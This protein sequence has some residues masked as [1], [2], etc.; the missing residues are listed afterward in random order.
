MLELKE[1]E[2]RLESENAELSQHL[3]EQEERVWIL[4][5]ELKKEALE[6][7]LHSLID[8]ADLRKE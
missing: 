1:K 7:S 2:A 8:V 5:S 6:A 4:K 3:R